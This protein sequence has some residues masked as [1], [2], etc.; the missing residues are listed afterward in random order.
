[1]RRRTRGQA[2]I[3]MGFVVVLLTFLAMGIVEVGY[4]FARTNM[5]VHSARD[6]ARFGATL[7]AGDPTL[8]DVTTGCLTGAGRSTIHDHVQQ[9]L[10]NIG[11]TAQNISV[12]QGCTGV[13][14][15]I[16]VTVTGP[17]QFLFN[18]VGTS[19]NVNRTVTFEDEARLCTGG[20]GC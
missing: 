15:T 10:D 12:S 11:F 17:L 2:L 7:G 18:L 5:I 3:E 1:M 16:A 4:A 9:S 14:P 13:V 8:R 19:V 6:G 20:G